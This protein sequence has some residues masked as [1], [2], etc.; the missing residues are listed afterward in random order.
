MTIGYIRC[1]DGPAEGRDR[2]TARFSKRWGIFLN[3]PI[4]YGARA[5]YV[6]GEQVDECDGLPVIAYHFEGRE[7]VVYDR[8]GQTCYKINLP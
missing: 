6:R 3:P 1:V 2:P 8:D 7:A 5:W 4:T